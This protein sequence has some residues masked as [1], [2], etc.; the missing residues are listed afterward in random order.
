MNASISIAAIRADGKSPPC[1]IGREQMNASYSTDGRW[2]I[3]QR[4][5][6]RHGAVPLDLS[7]VM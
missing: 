4:V 2:N 1:N 3:Y 6:V 7:C 5:V